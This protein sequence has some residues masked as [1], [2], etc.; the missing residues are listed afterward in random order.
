MSEEYPKYEGIVEVYF[1]K[2]DAKEL[3][4]S[5]IASMAMKDIRERY[6]DRFADEY[7]EEL[8]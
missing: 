4:S 8:L 5:M 7:P 2:K 3:L 1:A 6:M